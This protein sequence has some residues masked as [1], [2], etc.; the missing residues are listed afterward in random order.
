MD[1]KFETEINEAMRAEFIRLVEADQVDLDVIR[2]QERTT[3]QV[4]EWAMRHNCS[5]VSIIVTE[6]LWAESDEARVSI[7]FFG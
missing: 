2:K 5:E 4:V 3:P 1:P 7:L 6:S